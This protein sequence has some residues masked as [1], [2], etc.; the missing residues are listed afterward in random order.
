MKIIIFIMALGA[1]NVFAGETKT[2]C[3]A[4]NEN[5]EKTLKVQSVSPAKPS[6]AKTVS[7]Q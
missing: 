3:L 5:R 7:A 2:D 6:P 4:M 1:L